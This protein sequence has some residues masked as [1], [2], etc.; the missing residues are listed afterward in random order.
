MASYVARGGGRG[1][2]GRLDCVD[3]F[4]GVAAV[5]GCVFFDEVGEV[6]ALA[7][8]MLVGVWVRVLVRE[9]PGVRNC[10]AR[11]GDDVEGFC[12]IGERAARALVFF[13]STEGGTG[14]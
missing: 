7:Y 12:G 5:L 14:Y 1:R 8:G 9:D 13:E 2:V 11:C 10:P 6:R 4:V 3:E